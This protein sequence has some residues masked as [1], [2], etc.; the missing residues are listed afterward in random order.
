MPSETYILNL[1][2]KPR[3]EKKQWYDVHEI[4]KG[5]WYVQCNYCI[6]LFWASCEKY[7]EFLGFIY[8]L[9]VKSF[10]LVWMSFVTVDYIYNFTI[11]FCGRIIKA[12]RRTTAENQV[13]FFGSFFCEFWFDQGG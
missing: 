6:D 1:W 2:E 8:M 3:K 5:N 7:L 9:F 4:T 12:K 10:H 13:P 11:V